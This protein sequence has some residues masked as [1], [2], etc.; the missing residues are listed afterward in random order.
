MQAIARLRHRIIRYLTRYRTRRI[1]R[2]RM[3]QAT[4]EE[5]KLMK[6]LGF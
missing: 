4:P 3:A 2:E 5:R 1:V 6:R